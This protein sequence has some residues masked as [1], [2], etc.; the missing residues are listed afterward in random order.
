VVLR[1]T[2]R[3]HCIAVSANSLANAPLLQAIETTVASTPDVCAVVSI[4]VAHPNSSEALNRCS[5]VVQKSHSLFLLF[6]DL[7]WKVLC[8]DNVEPECY[9]SSDHESETT[10][11]S[12]AHC[13]SCTSD[14]RP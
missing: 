6:A 7:R 12:V 8:S 4:I 14:L 5:K 2:A 13:W 3:P 10:I 11:N 1:H 9:L